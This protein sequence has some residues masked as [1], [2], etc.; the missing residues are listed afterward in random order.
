MSE[1]DEMER[2]A[3]E[4]LLETGLRLQ[5]S[6]VEAAQQ[7][8]QTWC[9]GFSDPKRI[10]GRGIFDITVTWRLGSTYLTVKQDLK[11]QLQA[12]VKPET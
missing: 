12:M 6:R 7:Q 5:V 8:A 11:Q 2:M 1:Q 9:I 3:S 4:V 10:S